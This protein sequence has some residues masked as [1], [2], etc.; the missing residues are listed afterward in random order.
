[1]VILLVEISLSTCLVQ[2]KQ[3]KMFL[4]RGVL[5]V[6]SV[7]LL[8]GTA[9]CANILYLA[10]LPSPSHHVWNR[11]IINSLAS[12]SHN[13]TVLS[14]DFDAIPPKNVH[15]LKVNDI[16]QDESLTEYWKQS[17]EP[18]REQNFADWIHCVDVFSELCKGQC[19]G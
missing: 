9:E 18:V 12:H 16:Y 10:A 4:Y 15:Y 7:C 1:M 19:Q 13:V 5:I 3:I 8:F 2:G 6:I 11:E 17:F 14:P